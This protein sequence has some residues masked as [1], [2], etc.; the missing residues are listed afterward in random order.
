MEAGVRESVASPFRILALDGGGMRGVFTAA[1]LGEFERGLST[2]VLDTFD[3]IVGTSTGGIIGLGLAAGYTPKEMLGFYLEHGAEIFSRRRRFPIWLF[4]PRYNRQPLDDV[5]RTHFGER[6]MNELQKHVCITAHEL[7][8]GSTRVFKDDH[9]PDL[10]WGGEQLVWK[11]AA[12]TAAAP[13][14]FA[15]MQLG[16]QDSHVDGGVWANNPALVGLTEARRYFH[17]NL[18]QVRLL[19]VG[20][21]SRVFRVENHGRAS[22]MGFL[23]WALKVTDLLQGTVSMSSDRQARL[24]LPDGHYLRADSPTAERIPLDDIARCQPLQELGEQVA[25]ETLAHAKA[26]LA[27]S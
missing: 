11:V 6:R 5:L 26:T 19:S 1:Y 9:H 18:D 13:S 10:H 21:T 27:L 12:A 3:L 8:T 17:R 16:S 4:R 24:L 20:T 14:Y 23:R 25:R 7:V 2:S 15:P 22:R